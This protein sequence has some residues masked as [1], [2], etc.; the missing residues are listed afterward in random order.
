MSGYTGGNLAATVYGATST[1]GLGEVHLLPFDPTTTPALD[2]PWVLGRMS[3]LVNHAWDRR[4]PIVFPPASVPHAT[5]RGDDVRR[6]LDPNE[7]FRPALG[8]AAIMLALYSVFVGPV[9]FLR[10]RKKGKPLAPL[11]WAPIW[12][13]AAFGSI[14]LAGLAVKG[15]TGRSRQI[16]FVETGAGFNR[17]AIRRFRGFFTSET[18]SLRIAATDSAS[19][20]DVVRFDS[21]VTQSSSLGIDRDGLALDRIMSLPWQTLVVR[22]DG[23]M[24]LKGPIAVLKNDLPTGANV[25]VVNHTGKDLK[26]V[27]VWVPFDG[28]RWFPELKNGATVSSSMG[29]MAMSASARRASSAGGM[30]VHMLEASGLGGGLPKGDSERVSETWRIIETA[31]DENADWWPDDVPVVLAEMADPDHPSS[32]SGLRVESQRLL[33]RIVGYGGTK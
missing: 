25:D 16:A 28:A 6:A 29:V 24:D 14:V 4:A 33:M 2:D 26:D 5:W 18:R 10:A 27:I 19:V 9:T 30:T 3:D 11:K 23:F 31:T 21:L 17:G 7:N 32:D 13:A 12:S 15:W 1:Y 22:E 20:I 8:F